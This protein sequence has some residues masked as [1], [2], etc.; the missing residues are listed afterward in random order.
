MSRRL[1]YH[2]GRHRVKLRSPHPR[3]SCWTSWR[4]IARARDVYLFRHTS[5]STA[6]S[7]LQQD[8]YGRT[9]AWVHMTVFTVRATDGIRHSTAFSFIVLPLSFIFRR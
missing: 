7:S 5:I 8:A 6:A 3:Y 4:S 1:I 9:C 2:A